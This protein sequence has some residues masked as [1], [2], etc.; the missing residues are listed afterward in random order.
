MEEDK[1]NEINLKQYRNHVRKFPWALVIRIFTI[2][3]AIGIIYYT[4]TILNE[5]QNKI[6]QSADDADNELEIEIEN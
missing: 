5:N 3:I 4:V 1:D 2:T 6:I